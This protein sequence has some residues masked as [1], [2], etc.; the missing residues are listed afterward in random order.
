MTETLDVAV[1]REARTEEPRPPSLAVELRAGRPLIGTVISSVDPV[2]AERVAQTFDF[3]WIDLEHS[4]LSLSDAVT[5]A[6]AVRAG[7]AA[8]FV[9]LPRFDSE[10]LSAVLDTGVDGVVA[11][12]IPSAS[13]AARF[14]TSLRYPPEG[15][16]GFAPRRASRGSGGVTGTQ[17]A[18]IV[19]IETRAAI[20]D[21]DAIASTEG[22]DGLVVGLAD[23]S[24][25]LGCPL[26]LES[27]TLAAA[28]RR[29]GRAAARHGMPWGLAAGALTDWV[30]ES[31]TTGA[32]LLVFSSDVRLY[33]EALD[34][35]A[36]RLR[37]LRA[38]TPT[39]S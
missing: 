4:A 5:L 35:T 26:D 24:L 22:V 36:R 20:E 21:I 29:V 30:R 15:S 38:D 9:R 28:A 37:E 34:A 33:G 18:C 31:W 39:T 10:L 8:S 17:V 1:I 27:A 16:R 7:G 11:P 2:F 3:V 19:Q 25:D 6:I 13:E 23:L 32:N 12:K 14:V